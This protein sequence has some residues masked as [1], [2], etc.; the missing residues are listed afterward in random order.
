MST[1]TKFGQFARALREL[2]KV[3]ARVAREAAGDITK[4]MRK[5]FAAGRD[6]YGR[7]YAPLTA[8]SLQRGRRPPPLRKFRSRAVATPMA[9]SGI[10]IRINHPQAGFHQTGTSRMAQ[11]IVMPDGPVPA[12]WRAAIAK[13]LHDAVKER[14]G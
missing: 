14:L 13:R 11:R 9:G 8:G 10:S 4:L 6:P 3:P 1:P 7:A 5:N 2:A 12:P